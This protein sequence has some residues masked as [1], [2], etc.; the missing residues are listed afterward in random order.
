LTVIFQFFED[1]ILAG[2][3]ATCVNT[4]HCGIWKKA[5]SDT[6]KIASHPTINPNSINLS[7]FKDKYVIPVYRHH[8]DDCSRSNFTSK[9]GRSKG[10]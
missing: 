10:L 6:E 9:Y 1:E 8:L 4:C 2:N 5:K 7:I 3:S